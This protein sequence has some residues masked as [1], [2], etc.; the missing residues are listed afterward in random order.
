[1]YAGTLIMGLR[2]GSLVFSIA[3]SCFLTLLGRSCDATIMKS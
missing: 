1:M 3:W 2:L